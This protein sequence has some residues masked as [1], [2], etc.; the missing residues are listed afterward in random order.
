M[1]TLHANQ[2][3]ALG[4]GAADDDD[5]SGKQLWQTTEVRIPRT[6]KMR[7][8][9]DVVLVTVYWICDKTLKKNE[10]SLSCAL[11]LFI[12]RLLKVLVK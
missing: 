12:G 4:R 11:H 3:G 9:V 1:S 7:I 5:H 10:Q 8:F 2:F 6:R